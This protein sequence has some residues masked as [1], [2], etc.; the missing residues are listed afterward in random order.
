MFLFEQ[1]IVYYLLMAENVRP[2]IMVYNI[3]SHKAIY[4]KEPVL[5]CIYGKWMNLKYKFHLE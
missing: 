4:N 2:P 1:D 5:L 3:F